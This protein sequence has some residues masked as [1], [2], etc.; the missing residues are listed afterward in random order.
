MGSSVHAQGNY[1][2]KQLLPGN[3]GF[4]KG[5]SSVFS[6]T[7]PASSFLKKLHWQAVK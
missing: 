5:A 6:A 1:K 4:K 2:Y 7:S 3:P